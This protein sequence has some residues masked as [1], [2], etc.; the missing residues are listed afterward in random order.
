M[1]YQ[2]GCTLSDRLDA[3]LEVEE[4]SG[5]NA[6]YCSGCESL[7]TAR[8]KINI[9]QLPPILHFSLLRFVYDAKLGDRKKSKAKIAFPARI[10]MSEWLEGARGTKTEPVWYELRGVVE[11]RGASVS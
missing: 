10:D 11:H 5:A 4:L 9:N 1:S 6:Y 8:R 3:L 7:Q 2:D